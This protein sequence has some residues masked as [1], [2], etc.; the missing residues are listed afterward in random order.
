MS[1]THAPRLVVALLCS[2]ALLALPACHPEEEEDVRAAWEQLG[3]AFNARNGEAAAAALA[4]QSIRYFDRIM[5]LARTAGRQAMEELP[6][7]ERW[8]VVRIRNRCTTAEIKKMDGRGLLVYGTTQGWFI[9]D[10]D[11]P[12]TT[13][14]RIKV[15]GTSARAEIL[16]G[17]EPSDIWYDFY[18][19]ES[20]WKLDMTRGDERRNELMT[21]AMKRMGVHP[22]DFIVVYEEI[23]SGKAVR[24]DIWD[25]PK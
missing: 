2:L 8:E 25:P 9:D 6:I 12:V 20:G 7:G 14:G 23:D 21:R 10:P 17:D 19:E 22:S 5:D 1:A 24:R 3:A 13:L 18:K 16:F 15:S 11:D 4:T